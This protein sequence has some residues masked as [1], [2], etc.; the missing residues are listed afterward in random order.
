[1]TIRVD[2]PGGI[3]DVSLAAMTAGLAKMR[4]SDLDVHVTNDFVKVVR[5]IAADAGY[6]DDRN[7]GRVAARTVT[8]AG[9]SIVVANWAVLADLTN[10]EVERLLA[11]E[12]GHASIDSRGESLWGG[13]DAP[14]G[15]HW[16]N[17]QVARG[18]AVAVDEFRCEAAV[19]DAGYPPGIGLED[20]DVAEGLFGL[21]IQLLGADHDYQSHLDVERLRNDVLRA[22]VFH[23]RYMGKVAARDLH[24]VP[25]D[26]GG[27]NR[28]AR[29]NWEAFV[30]PTW[31]RLLN[32][33]RSVPTA[34]TPWVGRAPMDVG[35]ALVDLVAILMTSVGYEATED[36]FWIRISSPDRQVRL[37][38][39]NA[40]AALRGLL[41]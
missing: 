17:R 1:M 35:V 13:I 24:G 7:G 6:H 30:E 39:A 20:E 14:F 3:P 15:D 2:V 5:D 32:V 26:P 16:W 37:D 10:P 31:R 22:V 34:T 21:N 19:Y 33:Y 27:M 38:R 18:V 11:H 12:A 41:T 23:L 28:F 4:S 25:V 9:K 8:T 40:E 36:S 29:A